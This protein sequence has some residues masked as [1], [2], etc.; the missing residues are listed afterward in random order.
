MKLVIFIIFSVTSILAQTNH[1]SF[2]LLKN[3][4]I[5]ANNTGDNY[6]KLLLSDNSSHHN[7]SIINLTGQAVVGSALAVGFSILPLYADFVNS[8]SGHSSDVSQTSFAVLVISSYLFGA[9][10]GVYSIAKS[11]NSKLSY[12]GTVGYSAIGG[13]ASII[14][15]SALSLKYKT[16]PGAGGVII[17]LC[18][19][20]SSMLYAS[21]ISDWP[22]QNTNLSYSKK[23]FTLND[24]YNSTNIFNI[25]LI[26]LNL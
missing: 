13:G 23:I 1:L 8:W 22:Q 20:I 17:F 5:F 16:L 25:E 19:I 6:N 12:W 3:E 2:S 21:L 18:P 11:Q 15:A 24:L 7:Y 10:T 9:A 26:H 4:T 14:I